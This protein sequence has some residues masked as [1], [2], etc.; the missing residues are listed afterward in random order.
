MLPL[1]FSENSAVLHHITISQICR[2]HF[3][4]SKFGVLGIFDPSSPLMFGY[5]VAT[6][7]MAGKVTLWFPLTTLIVA[8]IDGTF[9]SGK[10]V[11]SY[12]SV[13]KKDLR[14]HPTN[15]FLHVRGFQ[16]CFLKAS[17]R[18]DQE[19][20][21]VKRSLL[22]KCGRCIEEAPVQCLFIHWMN[23]QWVRRTVGHKKC[24]EIKGQQIKKRE[25]IKGVTRRR[26][27]VQRA[28]DQSMKAT[29][30]VDSCRQ[31]FEAEIRHSIKLNGEEQKR[32]FNVSVSLCSI[33]AHREWL[34][35]ASCPHWGQA[36]H[37][38]S[39]A[40]S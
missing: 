37:G 22:L 24:E 5:I 30:L 26:G 2:F 7:G 40:I 4:I 34:K 6:G 29:S 27:C 16:G 23:Q 31:M 18:G 19:M 12:D 25:E 15:L 1:H 13:Q 8:D 38:C 33:R 36:E 20:H 39:L 10:G 14:V 32:K 17:G 21:M 9:G 35:H 28:T 3:Y 11:G